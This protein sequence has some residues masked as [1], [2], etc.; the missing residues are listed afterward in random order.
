[1]PPERV[2]ARAVVQAAD[3]LR[4]VMLNELKN[5]ARKSKRLTIA[6]RISENWLE[7]M[8]FASGKIVYSDGPAIHRHTTA[9]SSVAW[10]RRHFEDY[11]HYSGLSVQ[12]LKD[13]RILEIG[14]GD[15][16]G[17]ALLFLAYGARHVTCIDKYYSIRDPERELAIYALLRKDLDRP[18]RQRFDHAISLEGGIQCNPE[19]LT[20]IY[21]VRLEE[22]D[23]Q[24]RPSSFDLIIS[25]AVL[26]YLMFDRAFA[27]MDELLAPQGYMIH[28]I[29]LRDM[30]MFSRGDLHPLTFL[31]IPDPIYRWMRSDS[32][33]ANRSRISDYREKMK[34]LDYSTKILI[35]RVLG[36]EEEL[37]PHAE[38][39]RL[40]RDYTEE[41]LQLLEAIRPKLLRQFRDLPDED[42]LVTGICLVA[43]K[44]FQTYA[45]S[46]HSNPLSL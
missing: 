36:R 41:S 31:T 13:G 33:Q 6:Y 42:L 28:R 19:K 34:G 43:Q 5:F 39:L 40:G 20:A 32:P 35:T 16:Y 22:A 23:K 12:H 7:R 4:R 24:L 46:T 27:V 26:Q 1:M 15:N 14:H 3:Q 18:L 29:D 30:G 10:I 2:P 17:V 21:G 45:A 25:R 37:L 8:R 11:L 44:G 9:E 38:Q